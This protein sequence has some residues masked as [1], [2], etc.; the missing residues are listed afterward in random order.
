VGV[1]PETPDNVCD[2]LKARVLTF[3]QAVACYDFGPNAF[4]PMEPSFAHSVA[5]AKFG[6]EQDSDAE[7]DALLNDRNVGNYANLQ[8]QVANIVLESVPGVRHLRGQRGEKLVTEMMS[9]CYDH[10]LWMHGPPDSALNSLIIPAMRHI[11]GVMATLPPSH[12]KRV[13]CLSTLAYA[14]QDCQQVQAREIMRIYGDLTSQ[15]AS[16]EKQIKYSLVRDKEAALNRLISERHPRCDLDY[17]QVSPWQQRPHLVSGYTHLIGE[18]FGLDSVL[19]ARSDRFLGSAL[20]EISC[21][22]DEALIAELR[23]S[24]SIKDWLQMLLADINNQTEDAE[25]LIDRKCI[26]E[27]MQANMSTESAY[28]VFYDEDRRAEFAEF[29]PKEPTATNR[30][31][32]F[33]SLRVLVDVLSAAGFLCDR[34]TGSLQ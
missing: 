3:E 22:D 27:W 11:F 30:Y 7:S 18:T 6:G 20:A 16:L 2:Q 5:E 32:P 17:T 31:Q 26:F 12:G 33:L 34:D 29:E 24:M 1:A 19:S 23:S 21:E 10:G 14:C 15:N 28:L 9:A 13:D 25:R 8:G 4:G